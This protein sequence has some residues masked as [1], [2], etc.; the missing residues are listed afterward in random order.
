VNKKQCLD[1]IMH[2]RRLCITNTL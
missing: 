1:Y 2:K